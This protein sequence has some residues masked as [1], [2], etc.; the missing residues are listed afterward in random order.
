MHRVQLRDL[1][2]R[3]VGLPSTEYIATGKISADDVD[4]LIWQGIC[5][6][7]QVAEPVHLHAKQSESLSSGDNSYDYPSDF[8]KL[9][10]NA[11]CTAS[12]LP[13]VRVPE[14]FV[15][16][17]IDGNYPVPESQD[18]VYI[19]DVGLN[20]GTPSY[21]IWPT[22]SG[23]GTLKLYYLRVPT[24]LGDLAGDSTEYPDLPEMFHRYP[25][26]WAAYLFYQSN[27]DAP[28]KDPSPWLQIAQEKAQQLRKETNEQFLGDQRPR[29]ECNLFFAME[30]AYPNEYP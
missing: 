18:V 3:L 13:V 29:R 6:F 27:P 10:R 30:S 4:L 24:K 2:W 25:V 15:D 20:S 21:K 23:S 5:E 17:L 14:D 19:Y 26:F 22:P 11:Q 1:F 12:G 7:A 16:Q 28:A 9:R 8:W